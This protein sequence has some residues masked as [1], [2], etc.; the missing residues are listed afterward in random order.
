MKARVCMY[1]TKCLRVNTYLSDFSFR[2]SRTVHANQLCVFVFE[3][4][5][6]CV[7]AAHS[8]L[9]GCSFSAAIQQEKVLFFCFFFFSSNSQVSHVAAPLN[10]SSL[11]ASVKASRGRK[12]K[13]EAFLIGN[14]TSRN[15]SGSAS[16]MG[17]HM[18]IPSFVFNG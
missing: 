17:F 13:A 5:W 6:L 9:T 12:I 18:E 15:K 2:E 14:G 4:V 3:L 11:V 1:T 10:Q 7:R 16:E 8:N